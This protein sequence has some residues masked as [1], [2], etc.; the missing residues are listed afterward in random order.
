MKFFLQPLKLKHNRVWR[1]YYG[2]K[3]IDKFH[4]VK[5]PKDSHKPEEWVASIVRARN[6]GRNHIQDEGLSLLTTKNKIECTLKKLIEE[7]PKKMLGK[8]HIKKYS[9]NTGLLVKLLDSAER[10]TVQVHPDKSTAK[11][12]FNS[13]FGKT[14]AWHILGE[15]QIDGKPPYI[16]LGFKPHIT[17]KKWEKMFWEQDIKGMVNSLHKFY[18]KPGQTFLI[19]GG[20]P[21][22]IGA[23]CFLLE[24][25]EPTDYTIRVEKETPSGQKIP[26][27]LCHQGIG[28]DKMFDCFKYKTYKKED[29]LDKWLL[30]S[31]IAYESDSARKEVLID[32][33]K[34]SSFKMHLLEVNNSYLVSNKQN[35]FSVIIAVSGKGEISW[36]N[37]AIQ[38]KKGDQIFLPAELKRTKLSSLKQIPF[39][40]IRCFPPKL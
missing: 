38:I 21:H 35:V 10:L 27:K 2:G 8:S 23:G 31:Y 20:T 11:N 4:G 37:G 26:D 5:G 34:T 19:E 28:Y 30:K 3:L 14:E 40:V 9:N 39:S 36:E 17:R 1:T 6:P 18:V 7:E 12:L 16:L 29:I 15:R 33:K 32:Y 24:I 13:N 25:Q 22:A